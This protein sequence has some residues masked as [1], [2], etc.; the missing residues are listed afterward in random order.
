M[1]SWIHKAAYRSLFALVATI[2]LFSALPCRAQGFPPLTDEEIKMTSEPKAPGAPAVILFREVDRDDSRQ[3]S[4]HEDNYYRVKILSEDGRKFAN[5]QIPFIKNV[6]E[7]VHIQARTIKPDGSRVE[8]N[9]QIFEK[10]LVKARGL[11]VLAKTLTLPA[12]EPGCVIEYSY[13]LELHHAYASHWIL[14]EELFTKNARFSLRPMTGGIVPFTL[15][16]SWQLLPP[17]S[18]P[19][20]EADRTV[21]MEV[22]DIPP[23]QVED[24][25][26]PPNE[27]K[28]RVDFIYEIGRVE[29]DPN[30]F[31]KH[32][33]QVRDSQMEAFIAKRKGIDEVVAQ[34]IAPNDTPQDKLRKIYNRVHQ[35]RN[36]AFELRKTEQEEK[37][38][39]VKV[40][41]NVEDVLKRGYG[42][43]WQLDWLFL[44]M[45]RAAGL[46]AYG[47]WVS[48]RAEYFFNAAM[49]QSGHLNESAVLVKLNGQD[50]YFHPGSPF[51]PFGMLNWS[52]TAT[53]GW[54]MDKD[55]GGWVKTPLPKISDSRIE[56]VARL[57]LT[58]SGS[59]EGTLKVTYTGLEAMY[60][61]QDVR[62]SDDIARKKFLEDRIK[63]QIPGTVEVELTNKPDWSN[64]E[65]PLVA[66][67]HL[68]V[69]NWA[70]NA[71]KR[72][73][74]PAALFSAVEKRL[75]EHSERVH[76]IY[77]D[78][79]YEKEDDITIE[80][81]S[82]LQVDSVP[83]P[84]KQDGH[85][86]TYTLQVDNDHNTLHLQRKLGWDFLL[87]EP[88]FYPALRNFF[89]S[90]RTGDDQQI[91]L[92]PA[93]ATA[94]N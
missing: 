30:S 19:V 37:R 16:Q 7:V 45:V 26:P 82:G 11:K 27:L 89:Q 93:A 92:Q 29:N 73:L 62:N 86:I 44:A 91:V 50:L 4:V 3:G 47:C 6:D 24:F 77:I 8:F 63:N 83:P 67:Y 33:G 39:K 17:G 28:A 34:T 57:R 35:V 40:D 90:V 42:N 48:S 74:L 78:Y 32:V 70:S 65:T 18:K 54:R 87:L 41:E 2:A 23:F 51:V 88:K 15:R 49:M 59:L 79:P 58:D 36:T 66:E 21:T 14:S 69:S 72:T 81:P 31:W 68:T 64:P 20:T 5:V 85:I 52:E 13:T 84:Q 12:I 60:H 71:G 43:P 80:L 61:R 56:H 25:M 76:P 1:S 46:E 9:D 94:G 53:A 22:H 55:G 38:E 10:S 75:F